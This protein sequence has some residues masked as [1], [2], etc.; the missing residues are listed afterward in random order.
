MT[1]D[2][3]EILAAELKKLAVMATDK[4]TGAGVVSWVAKKLPN[5]TSC[6]RFQTP[7]DPESVLKSAYFDERSAATSSLSFRAKMCR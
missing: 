7:A 5:D 4:E 1:K 2:L 3:N 6:V